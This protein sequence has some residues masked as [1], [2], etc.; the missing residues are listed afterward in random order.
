[1][2]LEVEVLDQAQ[3]EVLLVL[4]RPIQ[5]AAVAEAPLMKTLLVQ[6]APVL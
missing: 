5:A 6:A 3:M 2:E 1:V 4:A